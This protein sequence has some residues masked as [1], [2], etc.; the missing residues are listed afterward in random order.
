MMRPSDS[1][2]I[3]GDGRSE[4]VAAQRNFNQTQQPVEFHSPEKPYPGRSHTLDETESMSHRDL[5]NATT[6][7]PQ[8]GRPGEFLTPTDKE[9]STAD[10][11]RVGNYKSAQKIRLTKKQSIEAGPFNTTIHT[12]GDLHS[13]EQ[14]PNV[15][16]AS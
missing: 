14:L 8:R 16:G 10:M 12:T 3:V 2:G 13:G 5:Y 11:T 6:T 7:S 9:A 15:K 4:L 1:V